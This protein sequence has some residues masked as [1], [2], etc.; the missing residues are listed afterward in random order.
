MRFEG[1]VRTHRTGGQ[2]IFA[3]FGQGER[4][5]RDSVNQR[6]AIVFRIVVQNESLF[7]SRL[8]EILCHRLVFRVECQVVL[9]VIR[10]VDHKHLFPVECGNGMGRSLI[11]TGSTGF[12]RSTGS[13]GFSATSGSACPT[14]VFRSTGFT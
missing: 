10:V 2:R 1:E 8:L 11:A 6:E 7:G 9:A 4:T 3:F 12:F 13:A 14:R 5:R